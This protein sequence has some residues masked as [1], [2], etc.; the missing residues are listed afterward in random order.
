M[1]KEFPD[2]THVRQ[3]HCASD[4]TTRNPEATKY[5]LARPLGSS[6]PIILTSLALD[7]NKSLITC[8]VLCYIMAAI[9]YCSLI[10]NICYKILFYLGEVSSVLEDTGRLHLREP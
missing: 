3:I 1:R 4:S 2:V 10:G 6:D 8:R 7:K 5:Y 9:F